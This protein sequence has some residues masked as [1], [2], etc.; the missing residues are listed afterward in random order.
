MKSFKDELDVLIT[1]AL[2]EDIGD[3]D[4]TTLCCI[5]SDKRGKAVLK[6]K[7][8]GILAGVELAEYIIKFNTEDVVFKKYKND[9]DR[10]MYGEIAF[11]LETFVHTILQCERL[12]LNCMQRMSGI[13]TLT[14]E[15][16]D[17]LKGYK[18]Q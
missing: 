1:A 13:A 17:K 9:G 12:I 7:D 10:M 5:P 4:H 3:G 14:R 8:D 15:Y 11:E 18:T 6:I 16:T 2:K